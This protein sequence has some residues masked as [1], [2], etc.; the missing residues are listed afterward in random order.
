MFWS[1]IYK[2]FKQLPKKS[3]QPSFVCM[4][5]YGTVGRDSF[6]YSKVIIEGKR[7]LFL[8]PSSRTDKVTTPKN[9]SVLT[10]W[11][12]CMTPCDTFSEIYSDFNK[13][14]SRHHESACFWALIP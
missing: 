12:V 5:P 1:V 6:T 13:L 8:A 9:Q 14:L 7:C 10:L 3:T 2:R 11:Y 4:A